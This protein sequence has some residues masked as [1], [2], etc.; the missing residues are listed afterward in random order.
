MA[1]LGWFEDPYAIHIAM[2]YIQNGDLGQFIA[3]RGPLA[4]AGARDIASQIL[5]GLVVLH[6]REISHR[7]LKPQACLIR[8]DE[9]TQADAFVEHPRG[10]ELAHLGQ[11]HGLRHLEELPR[12]GLAHPLRHRRLSG[13]RAPWTP[14]QGNRRDSAVVYEERRSLGLRRGCPRGADLRNTVP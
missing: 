1:F 10:V 12:I 7:D 13:P 3:D 5:E 8:A 2:E 6:E 4:R 9:K 11:D 14:A